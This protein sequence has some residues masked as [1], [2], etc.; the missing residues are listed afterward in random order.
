MTW[1]NGP[2]AY[3]SSVEVNVGIICACLPTLKAFMSRFFPKLLGVNSSSNNGGVGSTTRGTSGFRK[4]MFGNNGVPTMNRSMLRSQRGGG[5]GMGDLEMQKGLTTMDEGNKIQV[6][7]VVAQELEE[8]RE[9]DDDK[10]STHEIGEAGGARH[11]V[12]TVVG[13]NIV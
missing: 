10:S 3:W 1:D 4:S 6:V 11:G 2:A 13:T 8:L 7:T 5:D 9:D 12:Q